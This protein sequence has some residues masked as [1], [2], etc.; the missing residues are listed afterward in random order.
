MHIW[1]IFLSEIRCS[2]GF[3]FSF[4]LSILFLDILVS[5]QSNLVF[6]S[7]HL[8]ALSAIYLFKNCMEEM[9]GEGGIR[10]HSAALQEKKLK[11]LQPAVSKVMIANLLFI[12]IL[13]LEPVISQKTLI[14]EKGEITNFILKECTY[15][16]LLLL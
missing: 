5:S 10:S 8:V 15:T 7:Q 11:N 2:L 3:T 6:L 14:S 1:N 13:K 4:L 16:V 12:L 9:G